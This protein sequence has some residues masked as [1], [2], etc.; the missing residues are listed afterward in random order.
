M[1]ILRFKTDKEIYY[2]IPDG[3]IVRVM[4]GDLFNGLRE[5]SKTFIRR[6]IKLLPPVEPSKIVAI[7]VNYRNHAVEMGHEIPKEPL[8]FLKPSTAVIGHNDFINYP[9][10]SQRVDYEAELA[11]II[12]KKACKVPE[13]RAHEFILGYTCGNDVTARDLQKQDGQWSRAKGFDTFAPVGPKI[14]T[15]IDPSNLKI[16]SYLNG[17]LKQSSSTSNLIAPVPR[18]VSFISSVM[19]LL[20]GDI[21]LTGTPSGIGPMKDGDLIEVKIEKIGTLKNKVRKEN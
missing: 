4:E 5:T 6:D 11:V 3:E 19:T 1:K 17:E 7:G 8:I 14:V 10:S 12:G 16:E 20:P 2:G 13:E 15:D 21:I 9:L 18:L